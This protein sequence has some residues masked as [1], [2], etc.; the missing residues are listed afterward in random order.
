MTQNQDATPEFH[1]GDSPASIVQVPDHELIRLIG[2]GS[3]GEVWLAKSVLGPYRAVKIVYRCSFRD[4][5]PFEREFNGVQKFEPLSRLHDGLMDV[6]Q[7]GRNEEQGYFYCVMELAD[8]VVSGPSI[9]PERYLPKTLARDSAT[10]HRLP[11]AD[12]MRIGASIA[13]ALGFLHA[14]G[15]IHRD[16]KPSN[17]VFVNGV[18]KLADIGLV[19]EMSEARSYVGTDGFIPPEGPGTVQADIYSLGKVLYEISTG[20][21]RHDY[22]DPPTQLGDPVQSQEVFSLNRIIL[23]AC[24]PDPRIRYAS[25]AEMLAELEALQRGEDPWLKRRQRKRLWLAF[26]ICAGVGAPIFVAWLLSGSTPNTTETPGLDPRVR[27]ALSQ[28]VE[29]PADLVAWWPAE[30]DAI[31]SVSG[32]AALQ[33][34]GAT[35][36]AEG[37]V[38]KAFSFDGID[39]HIRIPDRPE[40]NFSGSMTIECWVRP[41]AY[42][43]LQNIIAKWDTVHQRNEHSFGLG[44]FQSGRLRFEVYGADRI[45][46][47][48]SGTTRLSL[49]EWTHIAAVYDGSHLKLFVN[50][51]LHNQVPYDKGVAA[52]KSDL[53]IGSTV[54]NLKPGEGIT[55]FAGQIDELSLYRRGLSDVEIKTIYL[56]GSHGKRPLAASRDLPTPPGLIAWWRGDGN[57]Q[58]SAGNHHGQL[59]NGAAFTLGKFGQAFS[60]DGKDDYVRVPNSEDF[61][62]GRAVTIEFWMKPDTNNFMDQCCQGI[63]VTDFCEVLISPGYGKDRVSGVNFSVLTDRGTGVPVSFTMKK[64]EDFLVSTA[65]PNGKAATVKEGQWHHVATTYDGSGMQLYINGEPWGRRAAQTGMIRPMPADSFLTLGSEDGQ[66]SYPPAIGTRYYHGLLDEIRIFN[67]ALS[68][69]E[70]ATSFEAAQ[71]IQSANR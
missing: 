3:Y 36:T 44:F 53:A 27:T 45:G 28:P 21:D 31:D 67:R 37:K 57:A 46:E 63:V 61:A 29:A 49:N 25:T 6:L 13:S 15:L 42:G 24:R 60:F 14:R 62:F 20:K 52:S 4:E 5:R 71:G 69:D 47:R 8:D 26:A 9:N 41:T 12:C 33:L 11:T 51:S 38:G 40:L 1:R 58:D 2:R 65:D 56:A 7:V 39:D 50:G 30:D 18:P 17:I 43:R 59:I 10:R 68:A 54:G 19:A 66:T 34:N 70:I 16:V 35:A 23:Q 48:V 22:P 32:V 64:L 55:A